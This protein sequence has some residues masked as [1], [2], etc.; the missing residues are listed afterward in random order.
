MASD[1][2]VNAVLG[3]PNLGGTSSDYA[4]Q[5]YHP[6]TGTS[7]GVMYGE[8]PEQALAR[9]NDIMG[10][11]N[12]PA[13]LQNIQQQIN[14]FSTQNPGVAPT[15]GQVANANNTTG[16]PVTIPGSTRPP[17]TA[18]TNPNTSP[19]SPYTSP[20]SPEASGAV[21]GGTSLNNTASAP[22]GGLQNLTP[23]APKTTGIG[24]GLPNPNGSPTAAS[25]S[26]YKPPMNMDG[27]DMAGQAKS[28]YDYLTSLGIPVQPFSVG[29]TSPWDTQI[30]NDI[31]MINDPNSTDAQ[32]RQAATDIST[33]LPKRN[34]SATGQVF[35][36]NPTT[37]SFQSN[38]PSVTGSTGNPGPG[39]NGP[40]TISST[41]TR[42][43]LSQLLSQFAGGSEAN[44]KEQRRLGESRFVTD[45]GNA[46]LA[47]R[48]A[49]ANRLASMGIQGG[50]AADMLNQAG[51]QALN[52]KDA[53]LANLDASIMQQQQQSKRDALN[54][55]LQMEGMDQNTANQMA[56]LAVT[57]RGQDINLGLAN[58]QSQM[59]LLTHLLDL[60]WAGDQSAQNQL[61]T[62]IQQI[63]MG[64]PQNTSGLP[65]GA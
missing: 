53:N 60:A 5:I 23:G 25:T 37:G 26:T 59:G 14:D 12:D 61:N 6:I 2:F 46:E 42:D 3:G 55:I 52:S 54:S 16:S 49:A 39:P 27:L 43:T 57:Q 33:L 50:A 8:T 24:P 44:A 1:A 31:K 40:G 7:V 65:A 38:G 36:Y 56:S 34:Q 63:I 11:G 22:T 15:A 51:A 45:A 18:S 41:S 30:N 32:R 4:Y 10:W 48:R 28:M 20:M 29:G 21:T 64:T 19:S 47:Q 35:T 58:N 62:L 9:Y 13:S 17:Q